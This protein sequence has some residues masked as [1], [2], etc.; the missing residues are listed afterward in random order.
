MDFANRFMNTSTGDLL[1]PPSEDTEAKAIRK[2][3]L[4]LGGKGGP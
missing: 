4:S 3:A 1:V 2:P